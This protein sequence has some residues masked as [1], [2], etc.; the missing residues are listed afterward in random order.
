MCQKERIVPKPWLQLGP[1]DFRGISISPVISKVFENCILKIYG[2]FLQSSPHQ[3]GFKKGLGCSHAIYSL[4]TVVNHYVSNGSTVNLCSLDLSKAFDK[5]NHYVLLMTLMKRNIPNNLLSI[6]EKWFTISVTCVKWINVFSSP[7]SLKAGTRQ[8]GILS[9]HL[10]AIFLDNMIEKVVASKVG[11]YMSRVCFNIIV[12]ADD[13]LLLSP[14]VSG[15]QS[16]VNICQHDLDSMGME[17]NHSKS[18]CMRIGLRFRNVCT[19]IRIDNEHCI[20]WTTNF[21]YLGMNLVQGVK[22]HCNFHEAR[23]KFN[24][25]FNAVY[26]K[27]AQ[28]VSLEC[29]FALLKSKCIPV[30]LYGTEALYINS[31]QKH[32][33]DFV[34]TRIM[35]KALSTSDKNIIH[36]CQ[37]NFNFLPP[38]VVI[39]MRR[40]KFL[41]KLSNWENSQYFSIINQAKSDYM[42]LCQTYGLYSVRGYPPGYPQI[43]N[44][45]KFKFYNK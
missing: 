3:F 6:L 36:D 21:T 27:I 26:G 13:I 28:S 8:G 30:L 14:T 45:I 7:F 15:L 43:S 40:A 10:F 9:P 38:S 12:Y 22:L 4:Q 37:V 41:C 19:E 44:C 1:T 31:S 11:C 34:S 17:I 25:A 32:S 5:M 23:A 24:R 29:L 42:S 18:M 16:L 35:I 39:D 2:N 33:L 20:A